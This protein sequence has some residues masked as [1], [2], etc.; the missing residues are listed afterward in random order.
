MKQN[1][2][3][4]AGHLYVGFDAVDSVLQR[5]IKRALRVFGN[6]AMVAELIIRSALLRKESRGLHFT[7]DHPEFSVIAKDTILVPMNFA[8]QELIVDKLD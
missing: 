1:G 8:N 2:D 4:I 5:A 6:L 3:A 7:L